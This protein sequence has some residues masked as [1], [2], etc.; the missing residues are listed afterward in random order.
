ML[1]IRSGLC[2]VR[3][4]AS[5]L[6]SR[7]GARVVPVVD[8]VRVGE[9]LACAV[10]LVPRVWVDESLVEDGDVGPVPQDGGDVVSTGLP[11]GAASWLPLDAGWDAVD[12]GFQGGVAWLGA[13]E[14]VVDVSALQFP[15]GDEPVPTEFVDGAPWF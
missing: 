14:R 3:T 13:D 9:G 1:L 10:Q 6:G 7:V 2:T 5:F 4:H 11:G 15:R 12:D 8:G